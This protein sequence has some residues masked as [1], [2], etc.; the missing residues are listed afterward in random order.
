M[1]NYLT[2]AKKRHERDKELEKFLDEWK[3]ELEEQRK[4]LLGL[5]ARV[6]GHE[7]VIYT[8]MNFRPS[9]EPEVVQSVYSEPIFAFPY[10]LSL[11]FRA[12]AMAMT[13]YG[14]P[15]ISVTVSPPLH[16]YIIRR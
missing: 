11:A 7:M 4:I 5:L 15:Q 1:M 6:Q 12:T 2:T 13:F 9:E 10:K 3:V 16:S 14:M 8:K